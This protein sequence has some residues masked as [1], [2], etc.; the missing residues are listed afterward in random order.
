MLGTLQNKDRAFPVHWPVERWMRSRLELRTFPGYS[1]GA[2][3]TPALNQACWSFGKTTEPTVVV[4]CSINSKYLDVF[5][6]RVYGNGPGTGQL[7][8]WMKKA[9]MSGGLQHFPHVWQ[10]VSN[11]S[12]PKV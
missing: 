5:S 2:N 3:T 1:R 4:F 11:R 8:K 6:T 10:E 9:A 12:K 7:K